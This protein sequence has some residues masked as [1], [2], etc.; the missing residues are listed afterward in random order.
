MKEVKLLTPDR[1]PMGAAMAD[2]LARGH[3]SRLRVFS[4]QFD[5]DEIPVKELFRTYSQMPLLEQ[6][7]LDQAEGRILDVG[8]GS[9]CHTLALQAAGKEVE[10]IDISPLAV[11][12]MRQRGVKQVRQADLFDDRFCGAYDT[13]L[14][15]MNGSGIIGRLENMPLFFRR[16]KS[17]LRPDGAVWMDSSDLR[18]LFEEEDGS[19]VIDLAGDYYGEV[20][21]RMQ[22]KEVK[23]EPFDW[24]YV[25]FQTLSCYA[26]ENGF[27][28]ELVKEGKHYDY[29]ARLTRAGQ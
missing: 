28:A 10:A 20:N 24:L 4:S 5:E 11:E 17:L 18:Y 19:F 22:Y 15:L 12:V 7:A 16:I 23:G 27:R 6:I 8:A 13:I 21:F 25:D 14:M 3:A 26:A 9:G 1:D 29:L 2:Y